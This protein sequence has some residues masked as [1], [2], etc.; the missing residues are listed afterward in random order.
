MNNAENRLDLR[1][2][3]RAIRQLKW[4]YLAA[5]VLLVGL[6]GYISFR[7]LPK[8]QIEGS[9]LIG[10]AEQESTKS[11][12]GLGQMMKTFSVG[13]FGASA[14]DNEVLILQSHEVMVRTVRS[15][16]L[17]RQYIGTDRQGKKAL[18]YHDTPVKI[19]APVEYFDTLTTTFTIKIELLEDGK[20]DV[21]VTK[22]LLGSVKK[23]VKGMQ[24]PGTL[25]TPY[26][27]FQILCTES[28]E[29]TPY[30][31]LKISVT[32]TEQAAINLGK[33]VDIDI[34]D[35]K[36]DVIS[37]N[38][39]WANAEQGKNIVNGIMNEYNAK[40]LDRRH[41]SARLTIKYFDERISDVFNN[42]QSTEKN[43]ADYQRENSLAGIKAET[44]LL[45]TTAHGNTNALIQT[46]NQIAYWEMV[47][48][49]LRNRLNE[50]VII[51]QMDSPNDPNIATFN[52]CIL[53][54]RELKR[55]ATDSNEVLILLN[56]KIESLRNVIIENSEKMI[57][58]AKQDLATQ[59]QLANKAESRLDQYPDMELEA[60]GMLRDQEFQ[61]KLYL[62]LLGE[63]ENAVLKLYSSSDVGFIYQPAFVVKKVGLL[64]KLILPLAGL[65]LALFGVTCLALILMWRSQRV[66]APIDLSFIGLD[67]HSVDFSDAGAT[68]HL[69]TM[70][71]NR[72][73]ISRI[74][75][76]DLAD[77]KTAANALAESLEKTGHR[78]LRISDC[79]S[80]DT[81]LSPEFTDRLNSG[82]STT[83]YIMIDIPEPRDV[84]ELE[85]AIDAEGA[86]LIAVIPTSMKR[87]EV[88]SILKGQTVDRIFAVIVQ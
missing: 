3:W 63:R 21:K 46:N 4:I 24:L 26:G 29:K 37:V 8:V 45:V 86:A 75:I 59:R 28:F 12:G 6:T 47:L 62:F 85:P 53:E 76:A 39:D 35:K 77:N 38:L 88:K 52:E 18:L 69:R 67:E 23:E 64:K 49:T 30:R 82:S 78:L 9:M 36:A 13:G 51:P 10:E 57:A 40:R 14:V 27:N 17:T 2:F 33:L 74:Y 61:N 80:N 5:T 87:A 81:I 70:L 55:S 22:G 11:A 60:Q 25:E 34:V 32:G 56:E 84:F 71:L 68:E 54:R 19:E 79:T 50:D 48:R 43:V 73:E 16:G 20:A 65:V 31:K 72:P 83:D 7:G 15:L 42:L 58:Q 66:K 1:R 41:E 44:K